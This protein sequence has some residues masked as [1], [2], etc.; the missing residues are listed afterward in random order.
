MSSHQSLRIV[1][2]LVGSSY[3]EWKYLEKVR[4]FEGQVDNLE[5]MLQESAKTLDETE[6]LLKEIKV[7]RE[8]CPSL[9]LL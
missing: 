3:E 8:A 5:Q 4:D 2:D 1:R 9:S 6:L 7:R